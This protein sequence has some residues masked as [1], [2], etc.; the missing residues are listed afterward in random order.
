MTMTAFNPAA[1]LDNWTNAGGGFAIQDRTVHLVAPVDDF[2]AAVARKGLT[3]Q[4]DPAERR[5]A[6]KALILARRA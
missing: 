5:E 3:D 6:V 2:N 4:L 1:W